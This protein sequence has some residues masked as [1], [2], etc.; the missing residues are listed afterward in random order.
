VTD[1][2]I[3]VQLRCSNTSAKCLS[4]LEQVLAIVDAHRDAWPPVEKW[5][6]LLPQWFV[7]SCVKPMSERDAAAWLVEWRKMTNEER[8]H[9]E[10]TR[11]WSLEN[12]LYLLEPHQR[13]WEWGCGIAVDLHT[14]EVKLCVD[15]WPAPLGAFAWLARASGATEVTVW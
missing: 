7:E 12:W 5:R 8:M 10:T 11:A 1:I 15:G 4:R 6:V 13:S 3:R 9:S 14:L 2:L